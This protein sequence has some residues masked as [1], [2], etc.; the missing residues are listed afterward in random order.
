MIVLNLQDL[1]SPFSNE[2]LLESCF[3][4]LFFFRRAFFESLISLG[5]GDEEI[6]EDL[7][8]LTYLFVSEAHLVRTLLVDS[9]SSHTDVLEDGESQRFCSR[10]RWGV[11]R[12]WYFSIFES[13]HKIFRRTLS[14]FGAWMFSSDGWAGWMSGTVHL[15]MRMS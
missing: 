10:E 12:F 3:R 1:K 5:T 6:S 11:T 4:I 7:L 9:R 2:K 13:S 15:E 8:R 14:T